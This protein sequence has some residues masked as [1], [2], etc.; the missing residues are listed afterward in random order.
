MLDIWTIQDP[1]DMLGILTLLDHLYVL[2]TV[3]LLDN[4]QAKKSASNVNLIFLAV[5][6]SSAMSLT[7]IVSHNIVSY[8]YFLLNKI[9]ASLNCMSYLYL[10]HRSF[11][12]L[13]VFA[14]VLLCLSIR[15]C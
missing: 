15:L 5:L 1:L 10:S 13:K 14:L 6:D 9:Y 12:L 7:V 2:D 4:R 8:Y 11:M 3:T